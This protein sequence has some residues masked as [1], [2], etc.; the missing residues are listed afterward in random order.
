MYV[1]TNKRRFRMTTDDYVTGQPWS[2]PPSRPPASSPPPRP[3][4]RPPLPFLDVDQSG[5][6]GCSP[7][8]ILSLREEGGRGRPRGVSTKRKGKK[9]GKEGWKRTDGVRK[10]KR[11]RGR[12]GGALDKRRR[13]E[14]GG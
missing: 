11:E 8:F 2:F 7:P 5:R 1:Y 13:R 12:E 6:L 9:G 3:P 10:G 4:S 14:R